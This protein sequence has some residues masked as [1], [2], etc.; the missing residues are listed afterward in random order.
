L[1]RYARVLAFVCLLSPKVGAVDQASSQAAAHFTRGLELAKQGDLESAASEFEAAHALVPHPAVLYNLGQTYASL[2]RPVD[3]VRTLERYLAEA[4]QLP[5]ARR[6]EVMELIAFHEKRIGQLV[7]SLQPAD[8]ELLLD[9]KPVPVA[10]IKAPVELAVGTHTLLARK[11]GYLPI[12]LSEL[13][14]SRQTTEVSIVLDRVSVKERAWLD[15]TC[16]VA[17]T[18]I[19]IDGQL[20]GRTPLQRPLAIEPGEH[21]VAFSRFGYDSSPVTIDTRRTSTLACNLARRARLSQANAGRLRIAGA[22]PHA[23]VLVDGQ[24]YLA[25]L[26]PPGPHTVSVVSPGHRPWTGT[27][28]LQ[29]GQTTLLD[30]D[31]APTRAERLRIAEAARSQRRTYAY[32]GAGV[33]AA[34]CSVAGVIYVANLERYEDYST[35]SQRISRQLSGRPA[36]AAE[37]R[38]LGE[39][40]NDAAAIE[41]MDYVA[42]S[43]GLVG[44][45]LF[46]SSV[47]LYVSSTSSD[48]P[49]ISGATLS[50]RGAV[51]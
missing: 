25:A 30:V 45:A 18:A 48:A 40:S 22:P 42:L 20:A 39:L 47:A 19:H 34:L 17:D 12:A 3:A 49:M 44:L 14:R 11:Q 5:T 32:L 29:Q 43:T 8:A 31:L 21:E 23:E 6:Q 28:N 38:Q 41:R 15:I 4:A 27:V 7:V 36:S 13:V 16:P 51:W 9:G 2:G 24:P 35:E 26:L 50:L 46:G 33:G 37:L 10:S 1:A